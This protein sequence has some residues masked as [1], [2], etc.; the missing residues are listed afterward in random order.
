M[1]MFKEVEIRSWSRLLACAAGGFF[2]GALIVGVVLLR[3]RTVG[4][5]A[6]A[7]RALTTLAGP[8]LSP[9]PAVVHYK[10]A[11][12]QAATDRADMAST[13]AALEARIKQF[14][15]SPYD[16][17]EVAEQ[18]LRRAQED[19]DKADYDAAEKAAT[20]SLAIIRNPNA[21]L[22][23]LAKVLS[24]R[25]DFREAIALANEQL[26]QKK[27]AGAYGIIATAELA[28]GE[29]PQAMDAANTALVMKPDTGNYMMRALVLEAQGRDAEAAF[30][31]ARAAAVES[32][33]DAP[34][35]AH[36]RALWGRFLLRRGDYAGA[37][38]VLAEAL[39][40][41][42]E[43]PLATAQ[44]A[45]LALRMGHAKEAAAEFET[46]FVASRQVRY[47]ID[48]A[49]AQELAGDKPGADSLRD[50]VETIVR[51]ELDEGGL[52]HRLDL[53]EVLVDRNAKI[54]EAIALA[55]DE[56]TRRPSVMSRF[57]L[58]RALARSGD[59]G[60][61]MTQVQAALATGAHEA[62]LYELAARLE[63]QKGG[64]PR[65]AMY[66]R[67]ADRYDPGRSGWRAL[68]MDG[69]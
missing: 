39:R 60:A 21:G 29:L 55:Q 34:G 24:A 30:D 59:T 57:Q 22:L 48:Q 20:A 27:S 41:V 9:D 23:T 62:E 58:A 46:A 67:E 68:G 53:V 61:A 11:I 7:A 45:E 51:G 17:N 54:S 63:R 49:R 64:G 3:G 2:L 31:F 4:G 6:P 36:L 43:F 25:H 37:Q 15:K 33:G 19:G 35:S 16:Y 44:E 69:K 10:F 13:I 18:Y 66:E 52:G 28:L 26:A 42:P 50:Q 65:A 47:L 12:T 14:G 56:V 8:D 1:V 32:Y 5:N 40:I 38:L